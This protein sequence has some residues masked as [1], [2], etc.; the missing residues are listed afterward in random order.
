MPQ[1]TYELC[2]SPNGTPFDPTRCIS[3]DKRVRIAW[4]WKTTPVAANYL[5][6]AWG[7]TGIRVESYSDLPRD[8]PPEQHLQ[9]QEHLDSM[10]TS[11]WPFDD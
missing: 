10:D 1:T 11:V 3:K 7:D 6:N 8:I 9:F 2:A 5:D 4:C